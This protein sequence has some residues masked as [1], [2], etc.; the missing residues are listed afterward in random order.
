M[1]N[2][3]QKEMSQ[4]GALDRAF[5]DSILDASE[6]E[7]REALEEEG[8]DRQELISRGRA[9][10]GRALAQTRGSVVAG[11]SA[12]QAPSNLQDLHRGLG[13]C[14]QLLRRTKK[15]SEEQLAEKARVPVDEVRRI[16]FDPSFTP[17]P[18]TLAQLE[19]F[20][21]LKPRS[22][23]VLSGAWRVER[24][25]ALREDVKRFAA[26]SSGMGKLTRE[27]KRLLAQF[28]KLLSSYAK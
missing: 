22:L 20:F 25:D 7:V 28:V 24:G 9:V 14:L 8:H 3:N 23:G 21:R 16:E 11:V 12:A 10:K 18:R 13:I 5:R 4:K 27:E 17:R 2:K 19:D 15:L 6:S 1:K 26:L